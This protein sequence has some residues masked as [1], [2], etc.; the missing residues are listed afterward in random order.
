[1]DLGWIT[2]FLVDMR[3]FHTD[4]FEVPLPDGHRFPM[5]K[6]R[7]VR[8]ALLARGILTA[9]QLAVPEAASDTQL[10]LVH[11]AAYLQKVRTGGLTPAEQRRIGFPWSPGLVERSARSVGATIAAGR[12]ALGD[13]LA[14]TLAGGTHHA[15]PDRGEGFCVFNDVAVAARVLQGEGL[16]SRVVVLDCDVHQGNG[17]AA[18]F[19]G[20][21]TVYTLSVF[22]AGN[23]PFR[24][25]VSDLDVPVPDGSDD[26]TYLEH[27]ERGVT[28]ALEAA[29]ADIAFY[30]AGAD[31]FR[32]DRLGRL[33]VSRSGLHERDRMVFSL[34]RAWGLPVA[35]TMAGGYARNVQDTVEI[36]IATV[37]EAADWS[38]HAS[39]REPT[40]EERAPW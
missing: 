31:P 21:P 22:G 9:S 1:M 15:Y 7:L 24:K 32:D 28:A 18:V 26:A 19:R 10:G 23:F 36:H 39:T 35:V 2:F 8:Q 30:V 6:Y 25:E 11:S 14:V 38:R 3:V 34:C 17:T 27:V 37:R 4:G 29:A 20:D 13:G 12:A 16:A 33:A 40:E 5:H